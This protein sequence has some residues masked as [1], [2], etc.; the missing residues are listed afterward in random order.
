MFKDQRS[1][2]STR[3]AVLVELWKCNVAMS[4]FILSKQFVMCKNWL[5]LGNQYFHLICVLIF[6][7]M[8]VTAFDNTS[9][10]C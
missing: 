3:R 6:I 9:F 2:R 7:F 10:G 4:K 1:T 8:V 5:A